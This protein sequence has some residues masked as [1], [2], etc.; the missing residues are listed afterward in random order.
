MATE[1]KATASDAGATR[2]RRVRAFRAKAWL[3]G[4][5]TALLIGLALQLGTSGASG[6]PTA[7]VLGG[8]L[9][10][11]FGLHRFGRLGPLDS[12]GG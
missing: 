1:Q 3:G 7:F 10:A 2:G 5:L 6:T 11:L 9:A 8:A 12:Q 4:G